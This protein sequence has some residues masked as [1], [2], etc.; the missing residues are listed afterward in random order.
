MTQYDIVYTIISMLIAML[1]SS[2]IIK[3][4]A[5]PKLSYI[6]VICIVLSRFIL[7]FSY[8]YVI[9]LVI[10]NHSKTYI[11]ILVVIVIT[12]FF[13]V[14]YNY[15]LMLISN[16]KI[17]LNDVMILSFKECA[18]LLIISIII[19]IA[20]LALTFFCRI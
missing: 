8:G 16:K 10:L 5:K 2:L 11:T 17:N 12:A 18:I 13:G 1:F 6:Q 14:F 15:I 7:I 19:S 3:K 4:F 9:G 20:I